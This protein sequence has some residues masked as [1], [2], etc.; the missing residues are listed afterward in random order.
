MDN[1]RN[2]FD[3]DLVPISL[4]NGESMMMTNRSAMSHIPAVT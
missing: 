1:P 3:N 4:D 2:I